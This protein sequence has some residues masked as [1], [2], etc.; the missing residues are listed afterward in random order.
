MDSSARIRL[1]RG[2]DGRP[3][4]SA[5]ADRSRRAALGVAGRGDGPSGREHELICR[6]DRVAC[7]SVALTRF[8]GRPFAGVDLLDRG[9]LDAEGF[10]DL[11]LFGQWEVGGHVVDRAAVQLERLA[12]R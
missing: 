6:A 9:G 12:M 8:T 5:R 2:P 10:E 4:T 3:S 7:P 1:A 11:R